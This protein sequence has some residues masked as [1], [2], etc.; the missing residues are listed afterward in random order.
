MGHGGGT[1]VRDLVRWLARSHDVLLIPLVR[2]GEDS[3]VAEVAELGARV[4][5]VPFVDRQ[6]RGAER[7]RLWAARAA[8]GLRGAVS[9]Y[10]LY[11]EKYW[12]P[13]LGRRIAA[14]LDAFGPDAVQVEYLQLALLLRHL[15]RER[16][17]RGARVPRLVLNTH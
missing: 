3:L 14:E 6:A 15:R 13:R 7:A 1:A 5:P 10:P 2:P 16:D 17:G 11:V 12:S 8:A 4:A 9:G